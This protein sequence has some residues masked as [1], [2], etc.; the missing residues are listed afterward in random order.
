[1]SG[2]A[3]YQGTDSHLSTFDDTPPRDTQPELSNVCLSI[4]R[5]GPPLRAV[6]MLGTLWTGVAHRRCAERHPCAGQRAER[7]RL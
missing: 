4:L 7:V 5:G 2:T 1:M 6:G 3:S